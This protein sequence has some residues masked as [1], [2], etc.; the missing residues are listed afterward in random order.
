[1]NGTSLQFALR[2]LQRAYSSRR[3]L[4]VMA[5]VAGLLGIAGPFGTFTLRLGAR[6]AYWGSIVFI[7]YGIG[8]FF[9]MLVLYYLR[10]PLRT[11]PFSIC[12][13]GLVA[14]LPIFIA[15]LALNWLFIGRDFGS[16]GAIVL[17][18]LYCFLAALGVS[19]VLVMAEKSAD[20]K[21]AANAPAPAP[22]PAAP[23]PPAI[24]KRL[25]V[26]QRGRLYGLSM[27]DHY[28][29]VATDRGR[30]LVL[31]RLSDAIAE[32]APVA[33]LQIHRS[34]WVALDAVARSG[35]SEGR[36]FVELLDGTRLPISRGY[37]EAARSA[38]LLI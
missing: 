12:I 32:T 36:G 33:G 15:V 9:G 17:Q 8:L 5:V 21:A 11:P 34:H 38:G 20:A 22:E 19:A 3:G 23:E 6:I 13:I 10:P 30:A 24:L 26:V 28:V 14:S 35:R 25:P 2:E 4:S 27:Q 37:I 29:E 31:M 16:P 7:T 1:V 18:W